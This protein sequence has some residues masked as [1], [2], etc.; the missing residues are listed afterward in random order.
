MMLIDQRPIEVEMRLIPGH[1]E[2]DL[3]IARLEKNLATIADNFLVAAHNGLAAS[4]TLESIL[5][6]R[7]K[8][9]VHPS[10][11]WGLFALYSLSLMYI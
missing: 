11:P 2:G 9:G 5:G 1:W 4:R 8:T 7:L 10:P 6:T 3:I